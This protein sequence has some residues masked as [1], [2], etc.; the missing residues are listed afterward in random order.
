M[1]WYLT[2]RKLPHN[3]CNCCSNSST[4][5]IKQS[6]QGALNSSLNS[7]QK[8][9]SQNKTLVS[10]WSR[11]DVQTWLKDNELT[12]L[13]DTFKRCKGSHLEDMYLS[14]C[15]DKKAF[16]DELKSDY[17]IDNAQTRREFVVALKD[18]FNEGQFDWG[19]ISMDRKQEE[20]EKEKEEEEKHLN[21]TLNMYHSLKH[22]K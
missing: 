8:V 17:G 9:C 10:Q 1:Y 21:I 16:N 11:E 3:L 7:P 5:P 2:K 4:G 6:Q 20:K 13:C 15:E 19:S 22:K 14:C 18:V 12:E